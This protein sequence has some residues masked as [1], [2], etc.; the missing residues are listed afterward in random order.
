MDMEKLVA[1]C[2][3]RGFIFQSSE[4]YGGING[5]WDYGPLGCELKKNIKDAWWQ[6]MVRNP[7][8]GPDGQEITMV[9]LDCAQ[10]MN[11]KVWEASGHVG[12]FSDP[13][14]DC[15]ACRGRFRADHLL[16]FTIIFPN[17]EKT[18]ISGLGSPQQILELNA[19]KLERWQKANGVIDVWPKP[20]AFGDLNEEGR[21]K[22]RC[23]TC[24]EEGML[25]EPRAFNLMFESHAG[26][27][28]DDANKVYLRP[29]TAQGMFVNFKNVLDS[30]RV[31]LPFGMA[32]IGK[33]FRNE[34]NPRN[35]TF[36]SREFEQMEIEFFCHPSESMKWYEYW[37]DLRKKWYSTLGIKSGNLKPREQGKE[38]LAHYSI[39]T[40]DIEYM[41]PFSEEP[42]ELEGVAHR[43]AF[44]LNAHM[45]HSGKDLSYFDEEAW[46]KD[47]AGRKTN[48]FKEWLKGNPAAEEI[49]KYQY[50]PHVIE[51]SAGA[52]RF[53]LAVLCEAYTEDKQPDSKGNL[54]E[55]LVMKFHPRLA[56]VKAAILPL[57]KKDGMPE[58]AEKLY[59]ELKQCFKVEYDD[60][61]AVGR[62]YRRQDEIGTPFCITIDGETL[63][64]DSVTIRDRDTLQQ[65][66]IP[67]TEVEAEIRK[68]LRSVS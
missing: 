34:I 23:P 35:Y 32:Q 33:A 26:A 28:K 21:M 43:G 44:D 66:R 31:K 39:G 54:E 40:T 48:S 9:G 59:R 46:S 14:V 42:Q 13:M 61:G 5:F 25:T 10:I 29:E 22:F 58:K 53:T 15:K 47:A 16:S 7:P 67:I 45:K 20:I 8:P 49:E 50:V 63:Q 41:F 18:L 19:K 24:D 37:R 51:P 1:L 52:D 64:N 62:R 60:S 65:R 36:R 6:D 17:G 68:A 57:V 12:G 38:E 3:R 30:S 55:R 4:I 27:I 11:P 2:R 56:P